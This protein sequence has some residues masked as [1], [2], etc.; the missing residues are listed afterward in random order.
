VINETLKAPD[1]MELLIKFGS[2][3]RV[4]SPQDFATFLAG[5]TRRW[6]DIAKAAN[7]SVD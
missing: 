3:A 4:G 1:M 2:E 6:A 5:E 7:V